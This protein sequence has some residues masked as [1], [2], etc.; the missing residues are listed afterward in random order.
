MI[1]GLLAGS[2]S[3]PAVAMLLGGFCVCQDREKKKNE[4]WWWKEKKIVWEIDT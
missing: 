2:R 3:P 4:R 1:V